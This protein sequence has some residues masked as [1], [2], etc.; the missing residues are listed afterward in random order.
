M[1]KLLKYGKKAFVWLKDY[2]YIPLLIVG[3]ILLWVIF[4]KKRVTPI[5]QTLTELQ[6][7]KAGR[8]AATAQELAGAELAKRYVEQ[9]YATEIKHLDEKQAEQAKELRDDP[10]KLA[11]FL[12]R[13]STSRN[14]P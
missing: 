2:W 13:V 10:V 1:K 4:R 5:Q 12:V 3:S 8:A 6:A 11:R 7:I 14:T 9:E